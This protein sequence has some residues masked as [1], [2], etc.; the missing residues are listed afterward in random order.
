LQE[1]YIANPESESI[2]LALQKLERETKNYKAANQI[3]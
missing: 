2:V 1:G 3:L